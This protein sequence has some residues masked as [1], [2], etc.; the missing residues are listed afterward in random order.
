MRPRRGP[1]HQENM[2]IVGCGHA[3]ARAA[4]ALRTNGWHGGITL[5]DGE[6]RTPYERPPLSKAVL[7]GESEAEDAP[8][9]PADFLAKNDIHVLK[10]VA[11]AAIDRPTRQLRLSDGGSIAYHR[12]LLATGA[13]PR[14]LIVPGADLPGSH[15]LRSADDAARIFPYLRPGAEIV[16]VGGG[17]IGLEAAA[18]ATVRGCKVT[19]V[20]AG[21]RPM[22]RAVPAELS[23]EVRLFHES[24]DVRFVLGRQVS[25]LEGDGRVRCV[26]LDDGTVLPCTAVVIS[27]G[28]SP[29]TALAEAAGLEIDNGIAVDRFLRTSDPFI[30]AAGDAC[31]FE[32]VSGPRMRLECWKNAED[33]G[34]LAGR[35]MLGSDEAY[36][37]LPWMWSD[38]FDRTMQIA[39]QA[40]GSAE[41]VRRRCPD[42]TLLIYHLD[43]DQMILGISGF[44]SIREVSRGVRMGQLL[45]ERGIR[46]G[47]KA[48]ADPEFDLRS[49]AKAAVA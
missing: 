5:V 34:T 26:R 47:R 42:G 11:A 33:Q 49:L 15:T 2:V 3:G 37:P 20:E 6:G 44:G 41:D 18:S 48:L 22:M 23:H 10:G 7:K 13:E 12:L 45:M 36:V 21:P 35:N 4:Q 25:E 14:N 17:L 27:V 32:Q 46:P 9:F 8:L 38:Q 39:G 16:I 40:G 31:A 1:V 30:Y 24:K 28:V 19:V 43:K 29:Q